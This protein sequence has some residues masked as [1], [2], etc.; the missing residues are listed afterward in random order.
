MNKSA[1]EKK[2]VEEQIIAVEKRKNVRYNKKGKDTAERN[3][4][5]QP[6]KMNK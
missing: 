3:R 6:S 1:N 4:R 5:K 2:D